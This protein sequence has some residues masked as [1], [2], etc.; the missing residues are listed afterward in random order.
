MEDY[1]L[2]VHI[3]LSSPSAEKFEFVVVVVGIV[4]VVII[5]VVVVN[6]LVM[7]NYGHEVLAKTPCLYQ[8]PNWSY[9]QK[10]KKGEMGV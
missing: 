7:E 3:P 5:I 2:E 4:I 8:V 1:G 9:G 6:I 10:T